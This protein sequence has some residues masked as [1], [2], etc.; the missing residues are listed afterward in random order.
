[1]FGVVFSGNPEGD[2]AFVVLVA[3]R[4]V[5]GCI[6]AHVLVLVRASFVRAL[7]L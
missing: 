5:E 4:D 1:M 2:M 6:V 3:V 7:L